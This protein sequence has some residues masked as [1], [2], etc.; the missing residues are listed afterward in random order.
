MIA[1]S[2][3]NLSQYKSKNVVKKQILIGLHCVYIAFRHVFPT[4]SF[5]SRTDAVSKPST[6]TITRCTRAFRCDLSIVVAILQIATNG[7]QC[8][9]YPAGDSIVGPTPRKGRFF[10]PHSR[11]PTSGCR[12]KSGMT[13]VQWHGYSP[14]RNA[15]RTLFKGVLQRMSLISYFLPRNEM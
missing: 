7:L 13:I 14:A 8:S 9:H 15:P 1:F 10:F 3:K 11:L 6:C 2:C 4:Q 5:P 12:I